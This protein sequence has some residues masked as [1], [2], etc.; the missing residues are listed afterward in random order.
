MNIIYFMG[1]KWRAFD[2]F[3]GL[4]YHIGGGENRLFYL[5]VFFFYVF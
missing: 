4:Q 1:F 5:I 3:E 2:E